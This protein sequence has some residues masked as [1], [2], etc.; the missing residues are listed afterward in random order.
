LKF[1]SPEKL[2]NIFLVHGED[3]QSLPLKEKIESKG[4][5]S[6]HYPQKGDQIEI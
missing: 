3:E 1:C 2:K 4:F 6:V 5:K